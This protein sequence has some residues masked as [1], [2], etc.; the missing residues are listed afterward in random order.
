[1]T[2]TDPSARRNLVEEL[3]EDFLA[4]HR[5]GERPDPDEYARR[6][7]ELADEIRDLFPA[8]MLIEEAGPPEPGDAAPGRLGDYRI[9]R[10]VGRG[11]MGV[12]YEAEQGA[13]GRRVALKVL[14]A[15]LA[16]DPVCLRRFQREARSAARLHHSNVVPVFDVG[17]VGGV[18]YYAMQF[19]DGQP[20]DAVLRRMRCP[21][22]LPGQ[23]PGGA[24]AA[25]DDG[26]VPGSHPTAYL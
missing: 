3:A 19:I 20:L 12:V 4:R 10:E 14:P 21:A 18:H 7:P 24:A 16:D 2:V 8:L 25:L 9:L 22:N 11:G 13:L 15:A 1:M 26:P 17:E 5:R 23:T 6:H